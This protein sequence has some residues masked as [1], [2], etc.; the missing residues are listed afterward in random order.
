MGVLCDSLDIQEMLKTCSCTGAIR[1]VL[2]LAS[3]LFVL[4]RSR[5]LW[6]PVIL[7]TVPVQS[8]HERSSHLALKDDITVLFHSDG[9]K[10]GLSFE[11]G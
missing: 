4:V 6:K 5:R 9:A 11:M 2:D 10:T 1:A 7:L 3:V 8:Q